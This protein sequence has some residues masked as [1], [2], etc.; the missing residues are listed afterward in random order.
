MDTSVE[1][2]SNARCGCLTVQSRIP[3]SSLLHPHPTEDLSQPTPLSL[4]P[5]CHCP[6]FP[7]LSPSVCLPFYPIPS[8]TCSMSFEPYYAGEPS[9]VTPRPFYVFNKTSYALMLRSLIKGTSP[10]LKEIMEA[11]PHHGLPTKRWKRLQGNLRIMYVDF[12]PKLIWKSCVQNLI[13]EPVEAWD[14]IF[15]QIH[16]PKNER[17]QIQHI[18]I[19]KCLEMLTR[20]YQYR[21]SR[22][23]L[24]V[25]DFR[26][27][28]S[29]CTCQQLLVSTASSPASFSLQDVATMYM[30]PTATSF[31]SSS[32][33]SLGGGLPSES[34]RDLALPYTPTSP[35]P[36]SSSHPSLDTPFL[37][38]SPLPY[39]EPL[40]LQHE[41]HRCFTPPSD[42]VLP[43]LL[44]P[45][46]PK[47]SAHY[48]RKSPKP[49]SI[50]STSTYPLSTRTDRVTLPSIHCVLQAYPS[51]KTR[52]EFSLL[53]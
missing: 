47:A 5:S 10:K 17:G 24:T 53:S 8:P 14:Q 18:K 27:M 32:N 1:S 50:D 33:L 38:S 42:L 26:R 9:S 25:E 4:V 20:R 16:M 30:T 52:A 12:H 41:L 43:P 31:A 7:P 29:Q 46:P 34:S 28:Y 19:Q 22:C 49:L 40:S 44:H 35:W 21:R 51:P 45:Y 15:Q 39:T 2:S 6:P 48:K 37:V 36:P 3:V 23:G 13:I 11:D